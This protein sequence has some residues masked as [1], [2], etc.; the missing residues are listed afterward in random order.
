M[1]NAIKNPLEPC[2]ATY[3]PHIFEAFGWLESK[4]RVNPALESEL[5]SGDFLFVN[6][7][8][9]LKDVRERNYY[10]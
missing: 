2:V 7:T 1:K 8:C 9:K 6:L 3:T 4:K 5:D 10:T